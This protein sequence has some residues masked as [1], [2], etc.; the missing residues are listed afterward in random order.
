MGATRRRVK[1]RPE[2]SKMAAWLR[3]TYGYCAAKNKECAQLL[4][5]LSAENE[6]LA[7]CA[8]KWVGVAERTP[9]EFV[10]VLV[11]IKDERLLPAVRE[12]YRVG[13]AFYVPSVCEFVRPDYWAE[14]P[15]SNVQ[16]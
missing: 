1:T 13:D 7:A 8:V 5:E 4:E 10:S 6:R 16:K 15:K 2:V 9:K 14:M 3:G 11:H 12:G